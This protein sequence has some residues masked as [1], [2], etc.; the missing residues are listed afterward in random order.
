MVSRTSSGA[1]L[2]LS[3]ILE[4]LVAIFLTAYGIPDEVDIGRII[5][6]SINIS[7]NSPEVSRLTGNII[8]SF[9][10]L[11]IGLW[12]IIFVQIFVGAYLLYRGD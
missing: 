5:V 4:L 3:G 11:S 7:S 12:L 8:L 2:L 10:I 1:A 6:K 9:D